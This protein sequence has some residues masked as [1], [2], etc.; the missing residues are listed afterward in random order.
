[1]IGPRQTFL[2]QKATSRAQ[3]LTW[4]PS[5]CTGVF[6]RSAT[7]APFNKFLAWQAGFLS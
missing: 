2:S 6:G 7:A 3:I 5:L 1:V 4:W